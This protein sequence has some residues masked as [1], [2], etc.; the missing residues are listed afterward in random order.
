MK[1]KILLIGTIL[2][3]LVAFAVSGQPGAVNASAIRSVNVTD[4]TKVI[5][6]NGTIYYNEQSDK[7][8]VYQNGQW[9]DMIGKVEGVSCSR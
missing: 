8:R 7:W 5:P 1:T 2:S 6:I 9:F 4:S 3:F